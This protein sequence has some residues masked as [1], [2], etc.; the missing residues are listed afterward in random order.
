MRLPHF[1]GNKPSISGAV[2]TATPSSPSSPSGGGGASDTTKKTKR[3]IFSKITPGVA[4]IMKDFDKDFGLKEISIEV[5]N[6]AQNV[7]ITVTKYNSKP[8]EVSKEKSG[9]TYKYLQINATNVESELEKATIKTQVKKSWVSDNG[10]AKD[11]ISLFRFNN[12]NW[13]ELPTIFDSEDT[14]NYYYNTELTSFSYFAIGE[15]VLVASPE[16][17]AGVPEEDGTGPIVDD[18]EEKTRN[19]TILVIVIVIII[20]LLILAGVGYKIKKRK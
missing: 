6:P 7:R 17:D 12:G 14:D 5:K 16:E 8:A 11:K 13:E 20:V 3:H 10:L 4:S 2:I 15:K 19:K 9:K 1:S 18:E